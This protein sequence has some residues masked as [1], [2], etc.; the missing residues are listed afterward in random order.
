MLVPREPLNVEALDRALEHLLTHH[1]SLRLRYQQTDSGWQQ[2]YAAPTTDSVL[3]QRQAQSV[4]QLNAL[5]DEAQRSLDLHNGPL[6]RALLG[7]DG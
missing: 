1:D 7:F 5:C 6:L 2:T 3:W 4:E